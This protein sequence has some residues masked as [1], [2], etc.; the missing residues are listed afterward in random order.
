MQARKTVMQHISIMIWLFESP[1]LSVSH[2]F[3]L[4]PSQSLQGLVLAKICQEMEC[5]AKGGSHASA[6]ARANARHCFQV[7]HAFSWVVGVE[8]PTFLEHFAKMEVLIHKSQDV[9]YVSKWCCKA[10]E[11]VN[12]EHHSLSFAN[13]SLL[14]TLATILKSIL[15]LLSRDQIYTM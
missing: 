14:C 6:K 11:Y 10:K 1:Y 7:Y 13:A 8:Q 12:S 5:S 15:V 3:P 2:V 4:R 9:D